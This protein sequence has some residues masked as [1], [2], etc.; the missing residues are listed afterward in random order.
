VL[1]FHI[2]VQGEP[3]P[4]FPERMY[5]YRY[6]A[7]DRYRLPVLS[8]AVLADDDPRWRPDH[9]QEE[10]LG[11]RVRLDYRLVK[12]LDY[13]ERIAELEQSENPFA[14]LILAHL[15]T[16]A[17]RPDRRR[18]YFKK[19]LLRLLL[20]KG[21][22]R[23]RIVRLFRLLDWLM[24]LPA[25]LQLEFK[26]DK[27]RIEEK[28]HMPILSTFELEAL[29]EGLARGR[30][31]G[32]QQGMQQGMQEG[33]QQGVPQGKAS[34]I[35]VFLESRFGTLPDALRGRIA[36][37]RDSDALDRLVRKAALAQSLAEFEG[38]LDAEGVAPSGG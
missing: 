29:Q 23:W 30:Q 25:G 4:A 5:V 1:L 3:D 27:R 12:V 9:Y 32:I 36:A 35:L 34:A 17:T 15:Y 24:V 26:R 14:L 13:R 2:D 38:A 16:R 8:M 18:L 21:Y 22:D 19:R 31:E 33:I 20:T 37:V 11:S 7:F 28:T 10:V 6:R